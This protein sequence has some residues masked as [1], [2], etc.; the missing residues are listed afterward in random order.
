MENEMIPYM[1]LVV[2]ATH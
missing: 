2:K 1:V